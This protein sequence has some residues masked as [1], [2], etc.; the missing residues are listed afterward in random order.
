MTFDGPTGHGKG[1]KCVGCQTFFE[2]LSLTVE[3]A[4]TL[5]KHAE[6]LEGYVRS[7]EGDS[8]WV[9]SKYQ[10]LVDNLSDMIMRFTYALEEPS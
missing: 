7:R 4:E 6:A 2:K 10:T 9:K 1:G 5:R 8:E 3:K